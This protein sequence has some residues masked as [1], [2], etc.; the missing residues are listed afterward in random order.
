MIGWVASGRRK[1]T[2]GGRRDQ[3]GRKPFLRDRRR[4]AVD[5]DGRDFQRIQEIADKSDR[6]VAEVLREAVREYLA[7][8]RRS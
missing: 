2:W 4:A 8:R 6:A 7:R 1:G 3:A 5:L